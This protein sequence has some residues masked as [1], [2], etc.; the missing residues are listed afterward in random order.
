MLRYGYN[1][2][3]ATG[4]LTPL[5]AGLLEREAECDLLTKDQARVLDMLEGSGDMR[6]RLRENSEYFRSA[7]RAFGR[8]RRRGRPGR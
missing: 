7:M 1:P 8:H 3:L 5:A 2:R 6:A 4:V